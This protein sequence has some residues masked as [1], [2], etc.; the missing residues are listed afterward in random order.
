VAGEVDDIDAGFTSGV[1]EAVLLQRRGSGDDIRAISDDGVSGHRAGAFGRRIPERRIRGLEDL[2][3]QHRRCTSSQPPSGAAHKSQ[4]APT[5]RTEID[6]DPSNTNR[7]CAWWRPG[8]GVRLAGSPSRPGAG[9]RR[10]RRELTVAC[11]VAGTGGPHDVTTLSFGPFVLGRGW[12]AALVGGSALLVDAVAVTDR[13]PV[14]SRSSREPQRRVRGQRGRSD[15][16]GLLARDAG[17]ARCNRPG[18]VLRAGGLRPDR[19]FRAAHRP[20]TVPGCSCW[21]A[22]RPSL[23]STRR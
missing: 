16:G 13:P 1:A 7:C 8:A 9:A 17:R 10:G 20:R 23:T 15:H 14:P 22:S 11:L 4:P 2:R 21:S 18:A 3:A 6:S 5:T 19:R 12:S